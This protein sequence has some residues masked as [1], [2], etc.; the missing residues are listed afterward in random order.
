MS[1]RDR[2]VWAVCIPD[3]RSKA[4]QEAASQRQDEQR[5]AGVE[6][7]GSIDAQ[8]TQQLMQ[9]LGPF[10]GSGITTVTQR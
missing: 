1:I 2:H 10:L 4:E 9:Q 8:T 7:G 6:C 3:F 5:Q